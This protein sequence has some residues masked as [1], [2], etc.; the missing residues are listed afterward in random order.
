MDQP[1]IG[2]GGKCNKKRPFYIIFYG[3]K[4]KLEIFLLQNIANSN[5]LVSDSKNCKSCI[6]GNNTELYGKISNLMKDNLQ[7]LEMMNSGQL[8]NKE[9]ESAKMGILINNQMINRFLSDGGDND[10]TFINLV[11]STLRTI[12]KGYSV[13]K[14]IDWIEDTVSF[15]RKIR[16]TPIPQ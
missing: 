11:I 14:L 16:K 9:Y 3:S 12:M 1:A 8:S 13:K 15:K 5:I 7:L 4:P 2:V 6:M 10:D